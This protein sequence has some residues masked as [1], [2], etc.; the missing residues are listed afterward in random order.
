MKIYKMITGHFSLFLYQII[1]KKF[2][3][4][5]DTL[6]HSKTVIPTTATYLT[7]LYKYQSIAQVI[8]FLDL[9][10]VIKGIKVVTA[11][12]HIIHYLKYYNYGNNSEKRS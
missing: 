6:R 1:Q 5:I 12:S 3:D 8:K 7:L 10:N 11:T 2:F 9:Y 4:L